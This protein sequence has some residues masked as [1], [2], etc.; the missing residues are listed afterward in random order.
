MIS[1]RVLVSGRVQGVWFRESTRREAS[2]LGLSGWVRNLPDGRVE[3]HF[4]GDEAA[5]EAAIAFIRRGPEHARVSD[6]TVEPCAPWANKDGANK[7]GAK[8]RPKDRAKDRDEGDSPRQGDF[9][10]R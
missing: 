8:D 3:A 2:A 5:V 1:R 9:E 10:I 7:D 6:V 4:E